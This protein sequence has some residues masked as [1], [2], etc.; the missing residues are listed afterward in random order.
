MPFDLAPSPRR[1]SPGKNAPAHD[2]VITPY[3]LA[4]QIVDHFKPSG[5]LCDPARGSAK[6]F[7]RAMRPYGKVEWFEL[8][9]GRDFL[10]VMP[11]VG[12]YDWIITNPPWSKL[13]AF[14]LQSMRL[15][16]NIVLLVTVPHI[17]TRARLRDMDQAGFGVAS[18]LRV[19]QPLPPWPS[20]GFQLAA[21]HIRRGAKPMLPWLPNGKVPP[22]VL[23]S[24]QQKSPQAHRR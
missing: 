19:V 6:P 18:M 9:D 12:R 23:P 21:I 5:R 13:R 20:S 17:A 4:Q 24:P 8:A 10:S 16:D 15:A 22:H 14:M 2:L 11:S 7:W 3:K 1:L